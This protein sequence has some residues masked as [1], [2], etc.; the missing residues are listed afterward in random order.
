[1]AL[2]LTHPLTEM[3]G[4]SGRCVRRTGNLTNFMFRLSC[5]LGVSNFWNPLRLSR[6]EISLLYL[7][8]F[9]L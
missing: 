7:T 5:N 6:S 4:K 3:G 1:M 8:L 2:G 9:Y